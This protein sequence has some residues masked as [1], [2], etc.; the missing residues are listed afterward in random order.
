MRFMIIIYNREEGLECLDEQAI[1]RLER[2]HEAMQTELAGTRELL[3]TA[4]L[5][6]S[7]ARVVRRTG[8]LPLVTDGAFMEGADPQQRV[9]AAGYYVVDCADL[10]RAVEIA[11]RFV[12]AEFAPIEV[13]AVNTPEPL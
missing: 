13:R 3:D 12:E 4:E 7:P 1:L 9:Y 11:G 10:E 5:S 6:P 2:V 8:G